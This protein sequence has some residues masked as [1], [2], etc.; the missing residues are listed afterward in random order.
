M[1]DNVLIVLTNCP[2]AD[3]ADRLA[4]TLVEQKLAACV[5][6]LPAVHSVY[7]WQ[8][9]VERAVEVPLLIKS[10]RERLPEIQEAIRAL[11]PYEVPEIVAI[12]VV[13]GL[14]AYLRWVVDETQPPLLA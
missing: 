4:R 10:T 13:A 14:P 1:I 2:D 8:G 5:N 9:S 7:R 12:P 6:R 3:V 11:H